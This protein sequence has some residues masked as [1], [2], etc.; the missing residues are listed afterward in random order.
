[1]TDSICHWTR[2][3][4]IVLIAID[5]SVSCGQ[6]VPNWLQSLPSHF[7]L[8]LFGNYKFAFQ[9]CVTFVSVHE[10]CGDSKLHRSAAE[11]NMDLQDWGGTKTSAEGLP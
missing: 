9:K 2:T 5:F 4:Q 6:I 1:M 3:V 10:V 11:N 7:P 8:S